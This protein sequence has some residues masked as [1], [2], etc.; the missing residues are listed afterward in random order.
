LLTAALRSLYG[1]IRVRKNVLIASS[2]ACVAISVPATAQD[3]ASAA[4]LRV[5]A[6]AGYDRIEIELDEEV[7]GEIVEGQKSGA[8]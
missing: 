3:N 4:G 2:A 8:I 5:E 1:Q 6:L 7:V